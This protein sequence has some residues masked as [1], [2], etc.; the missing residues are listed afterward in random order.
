MKFFSKCMEITPY[1]AHM[2]LSCTRGS[3]RKT[4]RWKVTS[5]LGG[6]QPARL[7]ATSYR[8]VMC[9]DCQLTIRMIAIQLDIKKEQDNH[10]RLGK[11]CAKTPTLCSVEAPHAGVSG[12]H[13]A[14]SNWILFRRV[15]TG[16][17][18]CA[19]SENW[20]SQLK[21]PTSSKPKKP[22]KSNWKVK[23]M[24]SH[25]SLSSGISSRGAHCRC[26]EVIKTTWQRRMGKGIRLEKDLF[27]EETM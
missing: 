3:K 17:D 5:R 2:F 16:V 20:S 13:S 9:G 11:I 23:I 12:H 14:T 22:R 1:H 10:R 19:Q 15:I 4:R 27:E 21:S 8:K 6:L 24:L 26:V 7:T 25:S 18:F